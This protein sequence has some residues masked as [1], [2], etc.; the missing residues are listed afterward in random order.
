ML[1]LFI[2]IHE[3]TSPEHFA[4]ACANFSIGLVRGGMTVEFVIA[5]GFSRLEYCFV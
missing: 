1:I 4:V 3:R 5:K 2:L